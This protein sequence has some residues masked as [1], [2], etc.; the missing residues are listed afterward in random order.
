M[1]SNQDC[2][3]GNFAFNP[4]SRLLHKINVNLGLMNFQLYMSISNKVAAAII[5]TN[6]F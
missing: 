1:S 3:L 6:D 4:E 5:I 2:R